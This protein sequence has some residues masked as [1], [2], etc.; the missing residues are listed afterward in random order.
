MCA[1][2]ALEQG[3]PRL[4]K[5]SPRARRTPPEGAFRPRAGRTPPEREFR[6]RAGQTPP[7]GACTFRAR[8]TLLEGR[9]AAPPWRATGATRNVIVSCTCFRFVS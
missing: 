7:E 2:G 9:S 1:S 5:R 8:R 6:P 4:R 3:G